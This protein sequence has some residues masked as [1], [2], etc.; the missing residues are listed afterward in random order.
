MTKK[1]QYLSD[2]KIHYE[3]LKS[4]VEEYNHNPGSNLEYIN[5][6]LGSTLS[7]V[8]AYIDTVWKFEAKDTMEC[9]EDTGTYSNEVGNQHE[10]RRDELFVACRYA[11]NMIKHSEI[12]ISHIAQSGGFSFPIHFP[13]EIPAMRVVWKNQHLDTKHKDQEEIYNRVFSGRGILETMDEVVE[14]IFKLKSM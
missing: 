10:Q 9:Q 1:E 3:N 7:A 2:I 13:L 8:V 4:A 11:N 12:L 14:I 5:A 6:Y